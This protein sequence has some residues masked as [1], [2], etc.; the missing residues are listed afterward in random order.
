MVIAAGTL[1]ALNV[2]QPYAITADGDVVEE[3]WDVTIDGETV[4]MAASEEEANQLVL[5]RLTLLNVLP[6]NR[7]LLYAFAKVQLY[8]MQLLIVPL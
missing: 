3:P 2:T 1:V 8:I 7:Q 6:P 4:C 5:T